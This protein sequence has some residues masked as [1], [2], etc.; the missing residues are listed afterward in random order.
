M[1]NVFGVNISEDDRR[2]YPEALLSCNGAS[3]R[4]IETVRPDM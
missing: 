2:V 4:D 1:T 3:R